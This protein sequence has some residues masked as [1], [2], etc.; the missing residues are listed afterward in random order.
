MVTGYLWAGMNA[1]Y[2]QTGVRCQFMTDR[3]SR[4]YTHAYD[5][6]W[7][8]MRRLWIQFSAS[9]CF[10]CKSTHRFTYISWIRPKCLRVSLIQASPLPND[11]TVFG[12]TLMQLSS[13]YKFSLFYNCSQTHQSH[14]YGP[15]IL[16]GETKACTGWLAS[17][18]TLGQVSM[19]DKFLCNSNSQ[20][21]W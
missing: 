17:W 11:S 6:I 1:N 21:F 7:V 18:F 13:D 9:R 8:C 3:H 14:F 15:V 10:M 20:L 19:W 2:R 12:F 4:T 16:R 5:Q